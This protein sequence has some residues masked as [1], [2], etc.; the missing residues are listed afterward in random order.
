MDTHFSALI[1]AWFIVPMAM[2]TLSL[3]VFYHN[4]RST[5]NRFFSAFLFC[6]STWL[7]IGL[8]YFAFKE[9][10]PRLIPVQ[11]V[12]GSWACTA[13][14]F[15]AR[16][17]AFEKYPFRALE[18]FVL[19]PS[20][21]ITG[22][23]L[24]LEIFTG[25]YE[26]FASTVHFENGA[27]HR[28]TTIHY[29]VY[30]AGILL[31]L[32]AGLWSLASAYRKTRD[33]LLR[34][35]I[36]TVMVF[37]AIGL[38][39]AV[40]INNILAIILGFRGFERYSLIPLLF[41]LSGIA[42]SLLRHKAW[43]IEYLMDIIEERNRSIE[44]ELDM[45]R[46]IQQKLL[47][48][49]AP[50]VRGIDFHAL[51]AP[52]DKVGGDYYD[53]YA[54]GDRL[55]VIIADVTGHGIPGAFLAAIT[56]TGFQFYEQMGITGAGLLDRLDSMISQKS[57]N[58]M[59][60]TASVAHL[61]MGRRRITLSR[62]GHCI[63]ILHRRSDDTIVELRGRGRAL[64]IGKGTFEEKTYPVASGD[65]IVLYT[66]GVE[67]T[68]SPAGEFFG[69]ERIYRWLR[70]AGEL[71]AGEACGS[72][73]RSLESFAGNAQRDDDVTMVVIDIM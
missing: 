45:A 48:R 17:F 49:G 36:S 31:C 43:T 16:A 44:S 47:P 59:F 57:V 7:S 73:M 71:G 12:F 15:F 27:I 46:L 5:A 25:P 62:A 40:F 9:T 42:V 4:R 33:P 69:T 22:Y 63:P 61:D 39:G 30:T 60:V 20:A 29:L 70:D 56:Q 32:L 54:D 52:M 18:T 50:S 38:F 19:I 26:S 21:Y 67:E 51:Y 65:R 35:R 3:T 8:F 6:G 58:S 68:A 37:L 1:T 24:V 41:S 34:R 55:D 2:Y 14:Y 10:A 53:F 23:C 64:G 66:D 72:L 28:E 11:M 13:F